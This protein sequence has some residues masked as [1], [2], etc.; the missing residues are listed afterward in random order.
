MQAPQRRV[1]GCAEN[2]VAHPIRTLPASS[3]VLTTVRSSVSEGRSQIAVLVILASFALRTSIG[4]SPEILTVELE[5]VE[6]G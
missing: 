5:Q 6:R 4:S 3:A 2:G 1:D